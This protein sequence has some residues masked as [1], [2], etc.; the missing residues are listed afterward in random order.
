MTRLV[1]A[2]SADNDHEPEELKMAKDNGLPR[3][4]NL[5]MQFFHAVDHLSI[6]SLLHILI[7]YIKLCPPE[8]EMAEDLVKKRRIRA[9]HRASATQTLTK[10]NDTLAAETADKERLSLLK[11]ALEEK[12]STFKLLD[13]EIVELRRMLLLQRSQVDDCKSDI[14]AA[15]VRIDKAQKRTTSLVSPTPARDVTP[16]RAPEPSVR[17]PKLSIK[18]FSGDI[19]Q[20]TTFWD[21]FKLGIDVDKF[22]YLRSLLERSARESIAGLALTA[23][24]REAL[25]KHATDYGPVA[26][27]RARECCTSAEES[28]STLQQC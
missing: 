20:W 2:L 27:S 24:T 22:N 5:S 16:A 17:L 11:L 9:G 10:V 23:Y 28:L 13:S 7:Y 12:L 3:V 15:L 26:E 1:L 8:P 21:S 25:R 4:T 19:T 18:T 6:M 14:Y